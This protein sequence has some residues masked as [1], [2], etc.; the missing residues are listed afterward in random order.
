MLG[1]GAI[2]EGVVYAESYDAVAAAV[3]GIGMAECAYK[4]CMEDAVQKLIRIMQT[5]PLVGQKVVEKALISYATQHPDKSDGVARVRA[6]IGLG[7][8]G[9]E[10]NC[11]EDQYEILRNRVELLCKINSGSACKFKHGDDPIALIDVWMMNRDKFQRCIDARN[12]M[13][14]QCYNGG[15]R[16][17]RE[18]VRIQENGRNKCDTLIT[19]YENLLRK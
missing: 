11:G 8:G 2:G 15:D 12:A 17:H 3:T 14:N 1:A 19:K 10:R 18:Q 16:G 4:S 13:N 7:D 6:E 9:G 5:H